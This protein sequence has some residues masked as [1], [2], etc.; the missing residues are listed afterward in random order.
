LEDVLQELADTISEAL[1]KGKADLGNGHKTE[2]RN[3]WLPKLLN[4]LETKSLVLLFDEFDAIDDSK[5]QDDSKYQKMSQD[6]FRY[7]R[8]LLTTSNPERLSFVFVIGRNIDDMDNIALGVFKGT[9]NERVSLLDYNDT[10]KLIRF[11]VENKSLQWSN[12]VIKG[13]WQ[14]TNGHPFLTQCLC[15]HV[16]NHLYDDVPNEPPVVTLENIEAA[17]PKTLDSSRSALEW[18]WDGL[19]P[20]EQV[21]ISAL[22]GAGAKPITED[23]LEKLLRESGV[24]VVIPE[25]QNAPRLLQAWDLI[26]PVDGGYRFR[27]EL[28]RRWVAKYKPLSRVQQEELDNI[29]PVANDFYNAGLG[30][31]RRSQLDEALT[32]LRQAVNLN[33]NH[34]GANQLLAEILL[35]QYKVTEACDVLEKL[36]EYQPS[37]A[38]PRLIQTLLTLAQNSDNESEHLRFYER[39]LEL[40]AEN[41]EAKNGLQT[42]WQQKGNRA[43]KRGDL[44]MALE[45]YRKAGVSDKVAEI[46]E[47]IQTQGQLP[48]WH[49]Q[50]LDALEKGDKQKAQKLLSQII[51][52]KPEYKEASRYLHLAVTGIDPIKLKKSNRNWLWFTL[53]AVVIAVVAIASAGWLFFDKLSQTQKYEELQTELQKTQN[54]NERLQQKIEQPQERL[55]PTLDQFVSQ[56]KAGTHVVIIAT[57]KSCEAAQKRVEEI[58]NMYPALRAKKFLNTKKQWLVQL[59]KFYSNKSADDLREYAFKHFPVFQKNK[60]YLINVKRKVHKEEHKSGECSLKHPL[61]SGRFVVIVETYVAKHG[62]QSAQRRVEKLKADHPELSTLKVNG[63]ALKVNKYQVKNGNWRVYIGSFSE[64]SANT[65]KDM[66]IEQGIIGDDAFVAKR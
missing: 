58:N 39:V 24:Q 52:I 9:R 59:G 20:A 25:L 7:L 42:I 22:A 33:P 27:V 62:R 47:K 26:E 64:S 54:D 14:L 10:V 53:I 50:A 57:T 3:V 29:E 60:P 46:E 18:L 12:E 1:G 13:V 66:A 44:D 40:D 11:S 31:Y 61:Q 6:F 17:I 65:F 23:Q 49:E 15:N 43:Y 55:S 32:P 35:A 38:R 8:D 2:F 4:N 45:T 19:P 51:A 48:G 30:L 36:Y 37:V 63:S 5:S 16:W 41:S 56:L 28:L 21:V 34:G